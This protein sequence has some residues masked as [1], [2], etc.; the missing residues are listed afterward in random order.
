M[1]TLRGSIKTGRN[2]N[3]LTFSLRKTLTGLL[4]L[5]R[6]ERFFFT[7]FLFDI[8]IILY[9]CNEL[10][11]F[12]RGLQDVLVSGAVFFTFNEHFILDR[13]KF[14]IVPLGPRP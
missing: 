4:L 5:T 13:A 7:L 8:R 11:C 14:T 10:N 9:G 6:D 3:I 2:I 12:R 1:Q